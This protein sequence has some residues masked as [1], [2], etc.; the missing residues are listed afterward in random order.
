MNKM[1]KKSNN[2]GTLKIDKQQSIH[3]MVDM[4][5]MVDHIHYLSKDESLEAVSL[6]YNVPVN[7]CYL[8]S[9]YSQ[10]FHA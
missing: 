2:Y 8:Y 9:V 7:I 6:K 10:S 3:K 1:V 5:D 4:V